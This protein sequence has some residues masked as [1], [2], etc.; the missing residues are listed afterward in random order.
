[1]TAFPD[2]RPLD[3][4]P[5]VDRHLEAVA[6]HLG[7]V[8]WEYALTIVREAEAHADAIR[9][10][11]PATAA[12]AGFAAGVDDVVARVRADAERLA[13]ELVDLRLRSTA[14]AR[15][16]SSNGNGSRPR[17]TSRPRRASL[18]DSPLAGLFE[19]T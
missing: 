12:N 14:A 17:A 5:A 8:L 4:S 13:D 6:E 19:A 7:A 3:R 18:R 10:A 1:M 11:G 16:A 2:S 15:P 9:R